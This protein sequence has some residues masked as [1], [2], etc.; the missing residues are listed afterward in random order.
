VQSHLDGEE[1]VRTIV[2]PGKLV[3]FVI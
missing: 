3:S 1:V 2:V